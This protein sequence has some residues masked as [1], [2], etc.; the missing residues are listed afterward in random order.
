MVA[1][2]ILLLPFQDQDGIF[3]TDGV[4]VC[5]ISFYPLKLQEMRVGSL[6][7]PG[8]RFFFSTLS[9]N[10]VDICLDVTLHLPDR[11]SIVIPM[12]LEKGML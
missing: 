3:A 7:D 11:N 2:I 12:L 9:L 6:Q 4:C 10:Q 5:S 1:V 8:E